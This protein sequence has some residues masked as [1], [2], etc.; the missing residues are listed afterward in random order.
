MRNLMSSFRKY[1]PWAVFSIICL[2]AEAICDLM[3]PTLLASI[4]DD[5]ILAGQ[6][7]LVWQLGSRMLLITFIG[8]ICAIGRAILSRHASQW[9][10][11]DLRLRVFTK[12]QRMPLT[13]A[14][15]YERASLVTRITNDVQQVQ[16]FVNGMMR[17]YM[18][19]PLLCVGATIMAITRSG[20][21]SLVLL[22][23]MPIA[24]A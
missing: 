19:A 16:G 10:G 11:H 17:F 15:K 8:M 4:I 18:R 7:S 5:G 21:L 22:V 2:T 6:S 13:S 14:D 3:Q 12:I 20:R 24:A 9:F 23:V 1:T